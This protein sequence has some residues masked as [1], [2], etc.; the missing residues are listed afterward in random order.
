MRLFKEC[1]TGFCLSAS[2]D[3]ALGES[4]HAAGFS[5]Y[6]SFKGQ[7]MNAACVGVLMGLLAV[8]TSAACSTI[9][10][11]FLEETLKLLSSAAIMGQLARR[12]NPGLWVTKE[13]GMWRRKRRRRGMWRRP[14]LLGRHDAPVGIPGCRH[15]KVSSCIYW[16]DGDF[17]PSDALLR[18]GHESTLHR[19]KDIFSFFQNLAPLNVYWP[20]NCFVLLSQWKEKSSSALLTAVAGTKIN[21]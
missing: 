9:L 16:R 12:T 13:M 19:I 20:I 3:E 11:L 7:E 17:L 8:K 15:P 21:K 14:R 5:L 6:S 4:F 2:V 10:S 1:A 18:L